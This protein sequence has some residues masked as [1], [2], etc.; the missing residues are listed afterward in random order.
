MPGLLGG[1]H[2]VELHL[3]APPLQEAQVHAQQH[4]GPVG[5][6]HPAGAGVHAE[7]RRPVVVLA[8]EEAL[9]LQVGQVGFDRRQVLDHLGGG[10]GVAFLLG[11]VEED[12]GVVEGAGEAIDPG[13]DRLV[14]RQAPG[15][16]PGPVGILPEVGGR[17][18][19]SQRLEAGRLGIDVKGTSGRRAGGCGGP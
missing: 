10:R 1:E 7:D 16:L 6:V 12:L 11:H 14:A 18:P 5:G 4:L 19:G 9:L 15:Q 2:L 13:D 8:E 17:R 3:E